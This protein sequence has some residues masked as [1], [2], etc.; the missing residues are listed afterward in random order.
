MIGGEFRVGANSAI[1][2]GVA[3]VLVVPK[4]Q[5]FVTLGDV[6]VWSS[7]FHSVLAIKEKES[8]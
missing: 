3:G 8:G 5:A 7:I 2:G 4:L 1:S 6:V